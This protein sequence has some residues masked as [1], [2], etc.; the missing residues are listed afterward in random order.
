[1]MKNLS[2]Y[3]DKGC[4]NLEILAFPHCRI[5]DDGLIEFLSSLYKESFLNLKELHLSNNLLCKN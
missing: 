5:G 2:K 1:M 4:S 3:L